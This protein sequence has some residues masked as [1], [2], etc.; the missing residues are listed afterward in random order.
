MIILGIIFGL[1]LYVFIARIVY[2][3]TVGMFNS[4]LEYSNDRE[5]RILCSV[6]FPITLTILLLVL[7]CKLPMKLA[8][9][10][11]NPKNYNYRIKLEK[12]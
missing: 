2:N 4:N 8:D 7:I 1:L 9:F 6:L 5:L 11:S 12:K 10:V 3:F